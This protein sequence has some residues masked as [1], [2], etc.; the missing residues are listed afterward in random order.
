M[1][2][3]QLIYLLFTIGFGMIIWVAYKT[4]YREGREDMKGKK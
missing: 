1:T 4:G 3:T 2:T